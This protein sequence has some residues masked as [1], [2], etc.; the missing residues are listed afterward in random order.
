MKTK[1][2][3]YRKAAALGGAATLMLIWLSLG[4]GILG[5]DGDRAN[6][7]YAAVLA[8]GV[9]GSVVVQFQAQGMSRVLVAMA[10]V[11]SVI[12][13]IALSVGVQDSGASPVAEIVLLNAFFVGMF[14]AAAWLFRS[15]APPHADGP[16]SAS[17][18]E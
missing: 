11:Q 13:V 1:N 14:L 10:A 7:M 2:P 6:M 4:V 15:A 18:S 17:A 9:I 16:I 3:T 5:A 8:T 12:T